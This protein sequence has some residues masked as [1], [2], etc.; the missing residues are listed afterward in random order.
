[1]NTQVHR[2]PHMTFLPTLKA[3]A[4]VAFL[5]LSAST[6]AFAAFGEEQSIGTQALVSVFGAIVGA[7]LSLRT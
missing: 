5:A 7:L 3:M 6:L 2:G 4:G 1:M